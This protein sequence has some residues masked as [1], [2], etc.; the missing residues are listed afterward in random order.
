[1]LD[2]RYYLIYCKT[3][4]EKYDVIIIGTGPAGI[5]AAWELISA[6]NKIRVLMLDK[7]GSL[8]ERIE[9]TKTGVHRA[10]TE[11]PDVISCGWG[12]AGAFSDGKLN[13]S[14]EVGGFLK[15]YIKEEGLFTLIDYVDKIYLKFGAPAEL[16]GADTQQI[17]ELEDDA[18]KNG[19]RFIP[20]PIRHLG[21]DRC[22]PVLGGFLSN[23]EERVTLRFHT[24]AAEVLCD[25]GKVTGV[26]LESGEEIK[27]DFVIIAPGRGGARWLEKE[28]KG[29]GLATLTNPVDIGVRIEVAAPVMKPLTDIAYEAK[30]AFYSKQFDDQVR[31]FCM[32]P[33]GEVVRE[34]H[35]NLCLVNGHSYS[36][37]RSNNTNFAILVSTVFT[38]PFHE[39]IAYGQYIARLA[40][41]LG[42]EIIVQRLGDLLQG[43]RSTHERIRRGTVRPT[44]PDATPGDLSFV[45][46]YRYLCDILE[47]LQAIDKLTPG[48]YARDT[49]L[50]GV[51]AKF[52]SMRIRLTSDFE[53][54]VQNLFAIGDG[55]GI[56]RGLIQASISGV[57]AAR[58]ILRRI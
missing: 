11:E 47:M 13:L 4:M 37:R 56:T 48:L 44:L 51:E 27:G 9:E 6:N 43:R 33:Y 36:T 34:Y 1:M 55:A 12:G 41:I 24:E 18:V 22:I 14:P 52:Y 40:N 39:P 3:V 10:K 23:M 20:F 42:G 31:T 53:T 32:N 50:Y 17:R 7:G 28:S 45:I 35:G 5:F 29:L 54:G 15:E 26:R 21:T 19:L 30:L 25:E 57:V 2:S 16:H 58:A 8:A 38:E 46:P 49:L